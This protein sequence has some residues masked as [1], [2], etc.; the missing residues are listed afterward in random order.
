MELNKQSS[1]LSRE[2]DQI[3]SEKIYR[4]GTESVFSISSKDKSDKPFR[5]AAEV[6]NSNQRP[7]QKNVVGS[8]SKFASNSA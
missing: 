7:T 5:K 8:C 2:S 3:Q 6:V 4:Y 1:G